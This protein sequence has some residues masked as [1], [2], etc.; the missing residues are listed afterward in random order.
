M[1]GLIVLIRH[2]RITIVAVMAVKAVTKVAKAVITVKVAIAKV[3]V[4]IGVRVAITTVAIIVIMHT[5]TV[6]VATTV[7]AV[8]AIAPV[9]SDRIT[10][11]VVIVVHNKG[12]M[13]TTVLADVRSSAVRATTP[14]QNIVI[15][16]RLNIRNSTWI[17]MRQSA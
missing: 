15:R 1:N 4:A 2:V 12:G 5:E 17:R 3:P 14:M 13:V 10:Q 11:E 8:M 9:V 7:K 16:S 6:K